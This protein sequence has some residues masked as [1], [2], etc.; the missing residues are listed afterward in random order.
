MSKDSKEIS[1]R[2]RRYVGI[3]LGDKK[4][5]VCVVGEQGEMIA[6]GVG[7]HSGSDRPVERAA[8]LECLEHWARTRYEESSRLTQVKGR[9]PDQFIFDMFFELNIAT[10]RLF[11]FNGFRDAVFG[12]YFDSSI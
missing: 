10:H 3:D 6:S 9:L 12:P 5:R 2:S 11:S 4:S 8:R 7:A 1:E